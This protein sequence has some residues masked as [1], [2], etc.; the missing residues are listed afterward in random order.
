MT[1][2]TKTK[3]K[4]PKKVKLEDNYGKVACKGVLGAAQLS[5]SSKDTRASKGFASQTAKKQHA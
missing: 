1:E 5:R 4:A 2:A 3:S